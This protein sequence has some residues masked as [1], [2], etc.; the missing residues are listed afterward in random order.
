M[1]LWILGYMPP[2][3]F[4]SGC[5]SLHSY[6]WY[7]GVPFS[8]H[9][10]HCLLFVCFLKNIYLFGYTG[11]PL[12]CEGFLQLWQ[13]RPTLCCSARASPYDGFS[14]CG[15][16]AL[17]CMGFSVYPTACGIVPDGT[18]VPCTGRWILNHW[19]T[20]EVLAV[21]CGFGFFCFFF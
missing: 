10:N 13:A 19:T 20:R 5:T 12:L 21:L 11:S 7:M 8:P 16:W 15:T 3:S 4:P 18:C 1:L 9:P 2:Y 17:G 14:C 6:Q